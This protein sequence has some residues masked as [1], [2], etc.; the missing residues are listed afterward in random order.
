MKLNRVGIDL[1][2]N[3]LDKF[4]KNTVREVSI[5]YIQKVV[6]DYFDIPIDIMKSKTRKNK[7]PPAENDKNGEN[8]TPPAP[9]RRRRKFF[10][11]F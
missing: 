3:M 2:K 5:D 11:G 6:C 8:K 1:A 4:V 7:N 10:R 9:A